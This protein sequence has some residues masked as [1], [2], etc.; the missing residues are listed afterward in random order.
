MQSDTITVSQF[1]T[2]IKTHLQGVGPVIV[3]GEIVQMNIT[4]RGG[5]SIELKDPKGSALVRVSGYAPRIQ[6][7]HTVKEGDSVAV[8]GTPTIWEAKGLF[9]LEA[10]KLMP[11]GEGALREAYEQ[12]KQKLQSEGLFD[13]DRKRQL[14]E[15]VRRIALVTAD[16]S[17]AQS[18][19]LKIL[20]ENEA[21]LE[22]DFYPVHVQG[23]YAESEIIS[24][25]K[26]ADTKDYDCIVLTRGGGSLEDLLAFNDEV[27][28]RT[29][30]ALSTPVIVGVGHER[31]ESIADFVADSRAST[32]SQAAYYLASLN[33]TFIDK[34]ERQ[35]EAL[36]RMLSETVQSYNRITAEAMHTITLQ[37][38]GIIGRYNSRLGRAELI[39]QRMAASVSSDIQTKIYRAVKQID[40]RLQHEIGGLFQK[41]D[42][43]LR[44]LDRVPVRVNKTVNKLDA[45]ERLLVSYNPKSVLDRGYALISSG[46]NYI[47]STTD[48]QP[49]AE[50]SVT[51]K[52]GSVDTIIS[53]INT[54][55]RKKTDHSGQARFA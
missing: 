32:P 46:G 39:M 29:I 12:L 18:D 28:A 43:A 22:I 50:L 44:I 20:R 10:F 19:F 3:E 34:L 24:A 47:S 6:G 30:F 5:V 31:D 55:G 36:R 41:T 35:T 54:D 21:G 7:I 26:L 53:K 13:E 42:R 14:P 51:L 8:W 37:T 38:S 11:L 49:G 1:N 45:L 33:H 16:G 2:M 25:L 15:F 48:L 9:S 4:Q 40:Y 52:D 27:L 17:A 23:R